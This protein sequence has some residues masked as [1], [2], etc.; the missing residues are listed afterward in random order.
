MSVGSDSGPTNNLIVKITQSIAKSPVHWVRYS[1]RYLPLE[2]FRWLRFCFVYKFAFQYSKRA[3]PMTHTTGYFHKHNCISLV[4]FVLHSMR[5]K[6][7]E[8]NNNMFSQNR[9][10]DTNIAAANKKI[11]SHIS[12][13]SADAVTLP[14]WTADSVFARRR[15][16]K[17]E[18]HASLLI[19]IDLRCAHRTQ[20]CLYARTYY[21]IDIPWPWMCALLLLACNEFNIIRLGA[22]SSIW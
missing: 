22:V 13:R 5:A 16:G 8:N 15:D 20:W 21:T 7:T 10:E 19:D 3:A 1:R 14:S 11:Y 9:F 6:P 17:T 12:N 18:L 2:I 4:L